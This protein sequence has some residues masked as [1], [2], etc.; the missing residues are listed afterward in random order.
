MLQS[1]Q[2]AV[3]KTKATTDNSEPEGE[4]AVDKRFLDKFESL[5]SAPPNDAIW[6]LNHWARNNAHELGDQKWWDV[7]IAKDPYLLLN[8][9]LRELTRDQEISVTL[10][11]LHDMI[12]AFDEGEDDEKLDAIGRRVWA[13]HH[14]S[15]NI[16]IADRNFPALVLANIVGTMDYCDGRSEYRE[17][18]WAIFQNMQTIVTN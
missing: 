7:M 2:A 12:I 10:S 18:L 1:T 3:P 17:L 8:E 13:L 16:L 6:K 14:H 4:N 9:P 15:E 11:N 5:R